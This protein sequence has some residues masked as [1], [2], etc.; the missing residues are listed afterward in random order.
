MSIESGL[1]SLSGALI[2]IGLTACAGGGRAPAPIVDAG[3]AP[4]VR[5]LPPAPAGHYRIQPGDTLYRIALDHGLD[6]ATLAAWNGL[7]NADRIRA[8]ELLRVKPPRRRDAAR[9]MPVSV[10]RGASSP[11]DA[12]TQDQAPLLWTWPSS[13]PLLARFGENLNKGIDI[14]GARGQPVRAA[15]AGKV[16]YVGSNLRGYGKLIIIRHGDALLSAYAHNQRI[17]IKEGQRVSLGQNIAE[18]GDSDAD[19]VKL[20]FEIREYGKPVDPLNYLPKSS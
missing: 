19:Q 4:A 9:G 7:A 14:A 5:A 8:G 3:R 13:G 6:Y 16:V 15:A 20:H 12:G 10:D 11:T 1:R 2:L 18:M 17:L